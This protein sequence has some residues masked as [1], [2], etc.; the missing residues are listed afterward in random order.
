MQLSES[1]KEIQLKRL[2]ALPY[3]PKTDEG[4]RDL[5]AGLEAA[6]TS[7]TEAVSIIDGIIRSAT[8]CPF[9]SDFYRI[10]RER[11]STPSGPNDG[12]I[13]PKCDGT[14]FVPVEGRCATVRFCE[15]RQR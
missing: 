2:S 3:F 7:D 14:T 8:R 1:C 15:C 9:P 12:E 4:M 10:V 11:A 5:V 13:C 6:A